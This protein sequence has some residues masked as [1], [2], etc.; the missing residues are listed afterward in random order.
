MKPDFSFK[1]QRSTVTETLTIV[2]REQKTEKK[3]R[4]GES[5]RVDY[6]EREREREHVTTVISASLIPEV[7]EF[8][9]SDDQFCMLRWQ[10]T[11]AAIG[12][13]LIGSAG[14]L[15]LARGLHNL[16][17][18]HNDDESCSSSVSELTNSMRIEE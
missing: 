11:A 12:F 13:A 16:C 3:P 14:L 7:S 6:A 2:E 5:T 1:G 9:S 8:L 4:P 15:G 10:A 18:R 17:T